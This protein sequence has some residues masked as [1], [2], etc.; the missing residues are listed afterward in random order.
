MQSMFTLGLCGGGS[1]VEW[2]TERWWVGQFFLRKS[3]STV[4]LKGGCIIHSHMY[5]CTIWWVFFCLFLININYN[6]VI[7]RNMIYK[8][9]T[10]QIYDI[11]YLGMT[12]KSFYKPAMK[13]RWPIFN[14]LQN[15]S[16]FNYLVSE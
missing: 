16:K 12:I 9:S 11:N 15:S 7:C 4:V 6:S 2:C 10:L 14:Q 13:P 1:Y 5:Q 3:V 8:H